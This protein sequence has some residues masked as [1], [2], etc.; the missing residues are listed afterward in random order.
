M[1]ADQIVSD[2][3]NNVNEILK[4]IEAAQALAAK[5]VQEWNKLGGSAAIAA[6]DFTDS[7]ITAA[8]VATAVS[9]M[10]G[11]MPDILGDHGTNFYKLKW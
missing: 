6:V 1:Q 11:A 7:D 9:S 10:S 3:R 8:D 5:T 2:V 4:H